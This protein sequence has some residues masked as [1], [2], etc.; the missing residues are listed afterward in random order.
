MLLTYAA[1][2]KIAALV[3]GGKDE[4]LLAACVDRGLTEVAQATNLE[5]IEK[6]LTLTAERYSGVNLVERLIMC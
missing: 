1:L 2:G 6:M 4:G 5:V 3:W